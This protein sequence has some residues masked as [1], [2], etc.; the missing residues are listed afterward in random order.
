MVARYEET[1]ARYRLLYPEL[2]DLRAEAQ[3]EAGPASARARRS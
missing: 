3:A 2:R 1:F